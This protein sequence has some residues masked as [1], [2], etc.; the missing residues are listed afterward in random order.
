MKRP[1]PARSYIR[2]MFEKNHL[3]FMA[4][5]VLGIVA[6]LAILFVSWTLGVVVDAIA[7]GDGGA[8]WRVARL[9]AVFMAGMTALELAHFRVRAEF[10]RRAGVRYKDAAFAA[11]SGK[12]ISAFTRESTGRYISVLTTDAQKVQ[13]DYLINILCLIPQPFLLIGTLWMMLR[14]SPLM[15]LATVILGLLSVSGSMILSPEYARR[16]RTV[17]DM[18]EGFV[19]KIKDLLS[20]FDLIKSFKAEAETSRV[21]AA[22]SAALEGA[23]FRRRWWAGVLNCTAMTLGISAQLGIFFIGAYLAIFR[24]SVSAGTVLIFVNLSGSLLNPIQTIPQNLAQMKAARGLI[25]K[26]G[27]IAS[28]NASRSGEAVEPVLRDAI[29]LRNVAFG[30]EPEK[31]VLRGLSMRLEAGKSYALVGASGSGK[32][33]LLNLLMGASTGYTGSLTVDGKELRDIDPDSLYDLESLIGQSVFLFDD[34]VRR[35]ITMFRDFPDQ[36][37]DSAVE[38]SGLSPVIAQKGGEYRCGEGGQGLSGGER[39]RVSIA[40]ALLR[41]TPVLLLDEATSALDNETAHA[42]TK[43]ILELQGLT[44]LVVTHRLD[45]TLLSRYDAVFVLRDG[46]LIESGAFSELMDKK[47]YFYSLY[48]VES[49]SDRD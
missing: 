16:E 43:A 12:S 11:V 49:S 4:A 40:R 1:D 36:R 42:V 19:G 15:T 41:G 14:E 45:P 35:N 21:F 6:E 20:G 33:T 37:V 47:G 44:R 30:Y 2:A 17:S 46:R 7:A 10:L 5:A 23:I 29:E 34:T 24:G 28:E 3:R 39:Q 18:N 48:T 25:T 32:S 27:D 38:R 26:L 31:P 13:D 22:E 8:L 9:T